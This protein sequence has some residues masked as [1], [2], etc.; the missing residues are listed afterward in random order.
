MTITR[1]SKIRF[2]RT[3]D[4]PG[5]TGTRPPTPRASIHTPRNQIYLLARSTA[6][7]QMLVM[8]QMQTPKVECKE[9][10]PM[11]IMCL[12][13]S[14]L[15]LTQQQSKSHVHLDQYHMTHQSQHLPQ[16]LRIRY[17][18]QDH[19]HQIGLLDSHLSLIFSK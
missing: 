17:N 11:Q 4:T 7:D 12:L 13:L 8:G 16:I 5:S 3:T 19:L 1:R 6:I 9:Q 15:L 18:I 14:K 10:K 2:Q